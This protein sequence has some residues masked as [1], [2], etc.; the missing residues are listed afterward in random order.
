MTASSPAHDL[1]QIRGPHEQVAEVARAEQQFEEREGRVHVARPG[2]V[3]R[4]PP[5]ASLSRRAI[6]AIWLSFDGQLRAQARQR[7]LK[8]ARSLWSTAILPARVVTRPSVASMRVSSF[9]VSATS[10]AACWSARL[11]AARAASAFARCADASDAV[12]AWAA[13]AG[14]P[15][16]RK[17][18]DERRRDERVC[19]ASETHV[20][21]SGGRAVTWCCDTPPDGLLWLLSYPP[22]VGGANVP[23]SGR[24]TVSLARAGEPRLS[25]PGV[26]SILAEGGARPCDSRS[27]TSA[28]SRSRST[29]WASTRP[30]SRP[31]S[32]PASS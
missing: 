28:G 17:D 7:V 31:R 15:S 23:P 26:S 32:A 6:S 11:A 13:R 16:G 2:P 12:A 30:T 22:R 21:T 4:A 8:R 10:C 14:V 18:G 19:D 5:A 3:R 24:Y 29:S 25:P 20:L 27:S 1:L 9:L